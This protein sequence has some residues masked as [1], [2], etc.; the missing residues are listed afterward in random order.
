MKSKRHAG[1][2]LVILSFFLMPVCAAA[3]CF[4]GIIVKS[5]GAWKLVETEH[6]VEIEVVVPFVDPVLPIDEQLAV[7]L[8]DAPFRRKVV[9]QPG[10]VFEDPREFLPTLTDSERAEYVGQ[11]S[12]DP[13]RR[14]AGWRMLGYYLLLRPAADG[15]VTILARGNRSFAPVSSRVPVQSGDIFMLIELGGCL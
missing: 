10:R 14:F 7:V 13:K 8:A 2:S 5:R 4:E 3:A 11:K 6:P 12:P 1:W 9:V 15:G